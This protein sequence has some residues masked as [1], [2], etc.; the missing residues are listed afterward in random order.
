MPSNLVK[1]TA[2]QSL[3]AAP[4]DRIPPAVWA[5][6][7]ASG[8]AAVVAL[9]TMLQPEQ[10]S[11][12]SGGEQLAVIKLALEYAYGKPEGPIKRKIVVE[13]GGSGDAVAAAMAALADR[14]ALPEY[15]TTARKSAIL[16]AAKAAD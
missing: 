8:E 12:L 1:I 10:F 7:C 9:K 5:S 13:T 2:S 11:A 16:D 4:T 3:P 15:A 6:L 14:T